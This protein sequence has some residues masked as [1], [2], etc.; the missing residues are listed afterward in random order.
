[1]TTFSSLNKS[2]YDK[3]GIRDIDEI[4]LDSRNGLVK[5]DENEQVTF[6]TLYDVLLM[7]VR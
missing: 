3:D 2:D 6:A 5:V 7:K 1:M 4:D